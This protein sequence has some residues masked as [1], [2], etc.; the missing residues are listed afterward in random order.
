[1]SITAIITDKTPRNGEPQFRFGRVNGTGKETV[2][3]VWPEGGKPWFGIF[4][5]G[6]SGGSDVT[7]LHLWPSAGRMFVVAGSKGYLIDTSNPQNWS[8]AHLSPITS[9]SSAAMDGLFVISDNLR[10]AAYSGESLLWKTSQISWNGI[11]NLEIASEGVRGEAWD[12]MWGAWVAF[13]IDIGTG[14]HQGGATFAFE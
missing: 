2:V 9:F 5:Q 6:V 4:P 14:K 3:R 13:L 1:M 8:S 11:R 10:V 12:D 7:G